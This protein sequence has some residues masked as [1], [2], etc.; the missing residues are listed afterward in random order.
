MIASCFGI[1]S[2][3]RSLG[4]FQAEPEV[5]H[6]AKGVKYIISDKIDILLRETYKELD[7]L[8]PPFLFKKF[9]FPVPETI[10]AQTVSPAVFGLT[11]ADTFPVSQ[12]LLVKLAS[13]IS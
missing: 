7:K 4:N 9:P 13:G 5:D 8:Y 2:P 12:I 10:A 3:I 11:E 1:S 6:E